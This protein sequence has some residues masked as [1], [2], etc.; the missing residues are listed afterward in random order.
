MQNINSHWKSLHFGAEVTVEYSKRVSFGLRTPMNLLIFLMY[1]LFVIAQLSYFIFLLSPPAR[2]FH[3]FS[4]TW[5]HLWWQ[6]YQQW[7]RQ[8]LES[9]LEP[10]SPSAL[11]FAC[12]TLPLTTP[13]GALYGDSFASLEVPFFFSF[14]HWQCTHSLTSS[15]D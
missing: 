14:Q 8:M 11:K 5:W 3:S 9:M 4:L 2:S 13:S 7:P 15:A 12:I 6:H 10:S 1:T